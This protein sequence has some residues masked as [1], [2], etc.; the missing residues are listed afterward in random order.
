MA[1]LSAEPH[2]DLYR[3]QFWRSRKTLTRNRLRHIGLDSCVSGIETNLLKRF[4]EVTL[5]FFWDRHGIGGI[6]I[7]NSRVGSFR[8]QRRQSGEGQCCCR[9]FASDV[10]W[11]FW[12]I[13]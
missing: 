9:S 4:T 6:W 8:H 10:I 7:S 3:Q 2:C 1:R 5:E 13:R 12:Q 11:P